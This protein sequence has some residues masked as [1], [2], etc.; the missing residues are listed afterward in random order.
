MGRIVVPMHARRR[1][2]HNVESL[3]EIQYVGDDGLRDI[4]HDYIEHHL[5]HAMAL[6]GPF[7]VALLAVCFMRGFLPV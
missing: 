7:V 5:W 2:L 6:D 1:M 3:M 4:R